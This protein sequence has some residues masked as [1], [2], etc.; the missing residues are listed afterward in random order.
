MAQVF[1]PVSKKHSLDTLWWVAREQ[2]RV[3]GLNI[4]GQKSA[5]KKLMS[6]N[7]T[8]LTGINTNIIGSVGQGK[9]KDLV[10][11]A[12]GDSDQWRDLSGSVSIQEGDHVNRIRLELSEKTLTG[13]VIMGDQSLALM[14]RDLIAD[15]VDITPL[16]PTLLGTKLPLSEVIT[17]FYM[18]WKGE[19]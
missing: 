18:S 1:D 5:Y 6:S 11:L 7:M 19:K 13:A 16:K 17:G 2:G 12:R 10:G 8:R 14:V 9:D 3:A 4:A 15:Q